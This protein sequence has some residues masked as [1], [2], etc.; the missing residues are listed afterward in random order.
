MKKKLSITSVKNGSLP[1]CVAKNDGEGPG[2]AAATM[3]G[4]AFSNRP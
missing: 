1:F 4:L 2:M 3:E